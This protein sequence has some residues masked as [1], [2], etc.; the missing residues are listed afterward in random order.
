MSPIESQSDLKIGHLLYSYTHFSL[1][2][3]ILRVF[4]K[5]SPSKVSHPIAC[6]LY[7]SLF[8]LLRR[9]IAQ[10]FASMDAERRCVVEAGGI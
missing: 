10:S 4:T 7:T 2:I 6:N 9:Q 8:V 1:E 3:L 5:L